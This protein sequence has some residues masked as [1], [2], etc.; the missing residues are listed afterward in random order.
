MT[1][2]LPKVFYL[3]AVILFVVSIFV[4]GPLVALGLASLSAGLLLS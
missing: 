1:I 3:V 2:T 4:A